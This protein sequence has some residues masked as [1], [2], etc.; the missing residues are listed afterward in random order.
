MDFLSRCRVNDQLQLDKINLFPM[1]YGGMISVSVDRILSNPINLYNQ[2][3]G[4]LL[5]SD[6]QGGLE[7]YI[8]ERCWML[9]WNSKPI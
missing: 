9:I 5:S 8:L 6:S 3:V 7:G 1:T 2:L 4:G